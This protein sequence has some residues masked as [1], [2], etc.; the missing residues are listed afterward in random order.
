MDLVH[1]DSVVEETRGVLVLFARERGE[2]IFRFKRGLV[3]LPSDHR[4]ERVHELGMRNYSAFRNVPKPSVVRVR[5]HVE[6]GNVRGGR[7]VLHEF[8]RDLLHGFFRLSVHDGRDLRAFVR[9]HVP[10]AHADR[11]ENQPVLQRLLDRPMESGNV[12]NVVERLQDAFLIRESEFVDRGSDKRER[13]FLYRR[14]ENVHERTDDP[15]RDV[16]LPRFQDRL[17]VVRGKVVRLER[18]TPG[19]VILAL[20]EPVGGFVILF[21]LLGKFGNVLRKGDLPFLSL[22][23]RELHGFKRGSDCHFAGLITSD[24]T[25]V[26]MKSKKMKKPSGT[27]RTVLC[28]N[29]FPG[30]SEALFCL[31]FRRKSYLSIRASD[32]D[33][34]RYLSVRIR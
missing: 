1:D 25:L 11:T 10:D 3:V 27:A 20:N 34:I 22:Q 26:F 16:L 7:V 8:V 2:E 6:D 33:R 15:D 32:H 21:R 28:F 9:L 23:V 4:T 30:T 13:A 19:V 5:K 14:D 24:N 18:V 31:E 12:G 17:P 29:E